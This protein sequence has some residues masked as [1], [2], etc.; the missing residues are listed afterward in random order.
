MPEQPQGQAVEATADRDQVRLTKSTQA[1]ATLLAVA[2]VGLGIV[3]LLFVWTTGWAAD[4]S[5]ATRLGIGALVFGAV[6]VLAWSLSAALNVFTQACVSPFEPQFLSP[7]LPMPVPVPVGPRGVTALRTRHDRVWRL[8][9]LIEHTARLLGAIPVPHAAPR[10]YIVTVTRGDELARADLLLPSRRP[11]RPLRGLARWLFPYARTSSGEGHGSGDRG[12]EPSSGRW[13]LLPDVSISEHAYSEGYA[14]E[15][16]PRGGLLL[17]AGHASDLLAPRNRWVARTWLAAAGERVL[18]GALLVSITAL[19]LALG[20]GP[21]S[22]RTSGG[23]SGASRAQASASTTTGPLPPTTSSAGQPRRLY[24]PMVANVVA[25]IVPVVVGTLAKPLAELGKGA[26]STPAELKKLAIDAVA[27]LAK[28]A[29]TKLGEALGDAIARWTGLTPSTQ[30]ATPSKEAKSQV[31][32]TLEQALEDQLRSRPE[33]IAAATRTGRT[34]EEIARELATTIAHELAEDL[35]QGLVRVPPSQALA[36]PFVATIA[37]GTAEQAA[38]SSRP[39]SRTPPPT[40]GQ[41]PSSRRSYVVQRDDSLWRIA[42]RLLGPGST[43]REVNQAWRAIYRTNR[44]TI[45]S[46]PGHIVPG[47]RLRIPTSLQV[48]PNRGWTVPL[49]VPP[50]VAALA[51]CWRRRIGR[52]RSRLNRRTRQKGML[53]DLGRC[54]SQWLPQAWAARDRS[55]PHNCHARVERALIRP[56]P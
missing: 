16:E 14:P 42:R 15:R 38:E 37:R 21:A 9:Y 24:G 52:G 30:P 31:Q 25:G 10:A 53:V 22:A 17:P 5:V 56:P 3:L 23:N 48:A 35:A 20:R 28:S 49:L 27:P 7:P 2:A 50:G 33:V 44:A 4:R 34:P 40:A 43:P 11:A 46:D 8:R 1:I 6:A 47:Q 13:L 55:G 12:E 29:S 32:T 19:V 41:P 39:P 45:G 36:D 26:A 54:L 51:A 18:A